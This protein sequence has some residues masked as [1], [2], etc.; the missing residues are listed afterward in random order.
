MFANQVLDKIVLAVAD[1]RA[2]RVRTRPPFELSMSFTLVSNPIGLS[3]KRLGLHTFWEAAR[4]RLYV[5][6]DMFGPIRWF[7]ELFY[8]EADRALKLSRQSTNGRERNPRGKLC[9]G[10]SSFIRTIRLIDPLTVICDSKLSLSSFSI[11]KCFLL[12]Q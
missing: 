1:V 12:L 6:V 2:I 9:R 8:L 11:G 3:F 10:D 7:L 5:L 4:E